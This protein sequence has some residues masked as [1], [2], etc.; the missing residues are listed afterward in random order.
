MNL[1]QEQVSDSD[2]SK[3]KFTVLLNV[4]ITYQRIPENLVAE[5]ERRMCNVLPVTRAGTGG[6]VTRPIAARPVSSVR[7]Q[8]TEA[9]VTP[10]Q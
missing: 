10:G 3:C 1:N 4:I 7:V 2:M 5:S 6:Q 9:G 8:S